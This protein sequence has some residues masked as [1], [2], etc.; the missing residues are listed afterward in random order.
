MFG[1]GYNRRDYYLDDT[2]IPEVQIIL[3][4]LGEHPTN[5]NTSSPNSVSP[6]KVS[7]FLPSQETDSNQVYMQVS[8]PLSSIQKIDSTSKI[9]DLH[10]RKSQLSSLVVNAKKNESL[11][12]L[13]NEQLHKQKSQTKERY[14][15]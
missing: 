4:P 6:T 11:L 3:D 9:H 7:F 15:W 5:N 10:D 8:Q 2:P 1:H 13:R 14:G 12:K